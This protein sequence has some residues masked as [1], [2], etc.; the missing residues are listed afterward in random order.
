MGSKD[1]PRRGTGGEA[2][3]RGGLEAMIGRSMASFLSR[4]PGVT[5]GPAGIVHSVKLSEYGIWEG[6]LK[7]EDKANLLIN[8]HDYWCGAKVDRELVV[9]EIRRKRYFVDQHQSQS[10]PSRVFKML[11]KEHA[12]L[13]CERGCLGLGPLKYYTTVEN[14]KIADEHEGMFITYA[15]GSRYSIASVTGAGSHVLVYCTT[16]D[17]NAW[18]DYEACVEISQPA[19]FSELVASAVAEHF[20]GRN[21][22]VRVEHSKC[23]YQHSRVIAGRLHGFSEALVQIGELSV[24][25]IDVLSDKKYLIK[26]STH[27]KDSEYRFAIVMRTD[28]PNYTVINCPQVVRFCRRVR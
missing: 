1:R 26:E 11:K 7:D 9:T 16:K 22:L 3:G 20:R 15:D 27:A 13:L 6:P 28:V 23:V 19:A 18:F 12:D 21:E 14:E 10:T 4:N 24:D 2:R 5:T 8:M 25:T 17:T